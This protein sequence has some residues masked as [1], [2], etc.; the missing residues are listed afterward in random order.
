MKILEFKENKPLKKMSL[1]NKLVII[2]S[3]I[4]FI[5]IT[6]DSTYLYIK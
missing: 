1:K 4:V 3:A 6:R 2:F 5:L